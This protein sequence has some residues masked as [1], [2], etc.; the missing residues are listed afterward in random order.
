MKRAALSF[1]I[2]VT[3]AAVGSAQA[4]AIPPAGQAPPA[5]QGRGGRGG[6]PIVSPEV[7]P[8]KTVTLRFRAPNAKTVEL[9]GELEGKPPYPMSK[10]EATGVWSVTIGPLPHDVYNYQFR[11]DAVNG[12]GGVIAMDPQNPSVKLG[13][14]AF[15][16]ASMFEIPGDG[17]E[18]DDAK[19]VPHGTVRVETYHSK[20]IGA[21]RT[22]WIY[23]PPGYDRG[24]TRYPVF[25]L[26]HGAGNIDSSW[27]LTGRANY[28]MDNLIAE[29]KTKPM[30]LVNP[31]GYARQGVGTGPE[32][33]QDRAAAQG[34]RGAAPPAPG[35]PAAQP[36]GLFGQDLL[37]DVIPFVEKTFRTLPGA[38]NRALG[39]LSMGGGQTVAI[40]FTHLDTFHWLVIMSAGAQ[41]AET[42]Y[43]D[44]F[45][46]DVANKKLKLL[47]MGI[48][49]DDALTGSGGKALD[50]AL[51]KANIK[52]TYQ[53]GEGRHEWVVWRHHL[54]D[55]APLLFQSSAA[56]TSTSSA[57][58]K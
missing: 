36:G 7:H 45:K 35:T 6:P 39:G 41:N 21:P 8:D 47:W 4:P 14:G 40:G 48:G 33:E 27:M 44:F 42:T 11:V 55:V 19:N 56:K 51:T 38:D 12:Q 20:T 5:G 31:L 49:K 50:E 10:D 30:I 46:P 22:L 18:F 43:P 1:V 26:L 54:R 37:T 29:G 52:H 32:R 17:L 13:F 25:Y 57:K 58:Q 16:P 23:T 9:I 28:I 3:A 34:G 24:T 2:A 53:V 15:P